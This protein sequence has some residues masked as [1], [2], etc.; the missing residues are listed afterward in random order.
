MQLLEDQLLIE[1]LNK[2]K[3]L[4]YQITLSGAFEWISRPLR[5]TAAGHEFAD[6]LNR[7]EVWE[8][9]KSGFKDAS[10][11]TLISASK[12]LLRAYIKKQAEKHLG[13]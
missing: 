2:D 13:L 6:A 10:I 7:K 9:L 4:G 1:R 12:E 8:A 3:H 11:S 5:L